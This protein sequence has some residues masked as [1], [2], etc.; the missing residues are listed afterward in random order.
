MPS[1]RGFAYGLLAGTLVLLLAVMLR[2]SA[3]TVQRAAPAKVV[4]VV[5]LEQRVMTPEVQAFGRVKP[6][7]VWQAVAELGGEVQDRHPQLETGRL[8]R[9]GTRL[10]TIDPLE[11]QLYLAQAR[12]D[13]N[14][15]QAQLTRLE[16]SA[17]NLDDTLALEQRRL[18][19]AEAELARK[20]R[21]HE[22]G[23]ASQS[24]LDN[25]QQSALSQRKL[26]QE[27]ENQRRL[28]PDDRRVAQAQLKV[29]EAALA[30]AKRRL[31]QT[32]ITLPFDGRIAV[33]DVEEGQVVTPNTVMLEAHGIDE[34]EVEVAVAQHDLRLLL[35]SERQGDSLLG[36][37]ATVTLATAGETLNWRATPTRIR[38]SADPSRATVGVVLE[39]HQ[40]DAYLDG[41]TQP[42]LI[43]GLFV[44]ARLQGRERWVWSV[45]QRALR[46]E[47][48]YLMDGEDRLEIL[49]VQVLFRQGDRV[50]IVARSGEP[51][52]SG[53]RV[54]LNDLIPA[55][56]GMELRVEEGT[57]TPDASSPEPVL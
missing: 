3:P 48:L 10:L 31:A 43:D 42:P 57:T 7:R 40:P 47:Q 23:L 27:L 1:K 30:D 41:A 35:P 45:P 15:A 21:L 53:L 51:L 38:A 50:A 9:A 56:A 4:Q 25:Q 28:L 36:L 46:G 33:V 22:Q 39:V 8:L 13:H 37:S 2:P 49:P 5:P 32:E 52:E 24:E 12:A 20:Q 17:V 44:E 18:A 16:Q 19:L 26:V 34:M 54:V 6:K 29:A 14:A 11:Y 55:V